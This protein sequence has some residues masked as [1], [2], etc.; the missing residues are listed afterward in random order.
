MKKTK[1]TLRRKAIADGKLSLYLDFYPPY[2]NKVTG[3][4]SRREF[5]KL[6]L[7]AKPKNVI[8]KMNNAEYQ[9]TA[10]LICIRRQNEMAK[11]DIYTPFE[12]EQL[13]IKEIGEK[14]FLEYFKK[15]ADKRYGNNQKIWL[16]AILHFTD[17]LESGELLFKD[18]TVALVDDY[19]DY[20]LSARSRRTGK[21]LARNTAFSY[22][23]KVKTTLKKAY[24]E[25]LLQRDINAGLECIKEQESDRNYLTMD[26]VISLFKAKCPKEQVKR[27]GLFAIL[28]GLRYSDIVKLKWKEVIVTQGEGYYIWFTQK[29]TEKPENLPISEEAF[30]IMGDRSADDKLVFPGLKKWDFDR[31][32]PVWVATAGIKKHITFHCF[33]HTYATLQIAGGTD[34]LTV[35]KMLGHKSIKT[36]QI[37]TKV[38]DE[39]KKEATERIKLTGT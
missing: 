10:E 21:K 26:E 31:L 11:D 2:F 35:S 34:I 24:K 9:K 1:V 6:Y 8:E 3:E 38:V 13:R 30:E 27:V 7:F 5:L 25:Q 32:I 22:Y 12:L 28:T 18:V 23:N 17:F 15:Q 39:R 19:R 33:R 37:Y 29:K 20:L 4:Y 16:S 36:T 14:S